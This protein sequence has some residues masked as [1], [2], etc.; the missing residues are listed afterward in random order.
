MNYQDVRNI[1]Y[2]PERKQ[3]VSFAALSGFSAGTISTF[4]I[5]YINIWLF[6][7]I[8]LRLDWLSILTAWL[9]WAVLGSLLAGLSGLSSEGFKSIAFSA[10]SMSFSILMLSSMQS[11]ESTTLK[12]VALVGLLFPIAAM[13]SPLAV[14]FFWLAR[15]FIQVM[16][17]KGWARLKILIV[18]F[19]IIFVIGVLPGLYVKMDSRSEKAVRVIHQILQDARTSAPDVLHKSLL[20]TEGFA[21]RKSQPYTL[22]QAAS[23]YSTVGV[24]VTVHYEDG[25]KMTCTVVM[26]PGSEPSIY[27]CKFLAP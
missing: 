14:I 10:V 24:D 18:N 4:I 17:L 25:Y 2:D 11:S 26:Y 9:L 3:R 6:P 13:L 16:S 19:L 23:I 27:P 20:K 7:D 21:D 1:P 5:A 15:R 8:P 12:I 22:S